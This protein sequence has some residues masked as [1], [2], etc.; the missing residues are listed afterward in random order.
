MKPATFTA[1]QLAFPTR[2]SAPQLFPTP[3]DI[4][5][6]V[7][8][9]A[10]IKPGHR[11]LEPSAGTGRLLDPMFNADATGALFDPD[12][13]R[14]VGLLVAVEI[15]PQLAKLLRTQYACASV[16]NQDFLTCNGDL[17][18]FDR[19]VMNPP[20][21]DGSDIRHINHAYMML[22]PGGRLVAVCA[23]GPRQYKAFHD[24]ATEWI[25]L[26]AD[27]FKDEGTSVNT[28]IIVLEKP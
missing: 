3:I 2:I 24:I 7:V 8:E 18:T 11:V 22:K 15:N 20:F 9:L 5:Q 13:S 26:P 23:A 28:A 12:N 17:G 16:I 10:D 6:R 19:V 25:D 27:S 14:P 1:A 21:K 4:A